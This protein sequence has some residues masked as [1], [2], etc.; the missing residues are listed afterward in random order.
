LALGA[1]PAF[2]GAG[3]AADLHGRIVIAPSIDYL[4]RAFD[5]SKYGELPQEPYLDVT[6][7]T[8]SDPSLA[9][10]GKHVLSAHVQ[11]VPYRMSGDM[12]LHDAHKALASRVIGILDRHAPGLAAQVEATQVL[13]PI[14]LEETYGISGG[15]IYHGEPALDQLFTMRPLL[16]WAQY[17]TPVDGLYLCGSGTHPG[18]GITA[19]SGENAA[20]QIARSLRR[21]AS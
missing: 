6:I 10:S 19:A 18:G 17:R 4:E 16:G 21:P 9:P 3:N 5:A 2:R 20:K 14:D 8:L 12:T 13:L 1:L 11:F 7:P 15:Q